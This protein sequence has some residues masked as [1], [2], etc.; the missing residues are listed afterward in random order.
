V[1][2]QAHIPF[3]PLIRKGIPLQLFKRAFLPPFIL[4]NFDPLQT[5]FNEWIGPFTVRIT[6]EHVH[7]QK[8][9]RL[10]SKYTFYLKLHYLLM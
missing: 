10:F 7:R 5:L 2:T 6:H 4:K 3:P 1:N 9:K 8:R